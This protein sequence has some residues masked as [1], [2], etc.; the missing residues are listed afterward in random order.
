VKNEELN[1][2]KVAFI[3]CVNDEE[4]YSEALL[5]QKQLVIPSGMEAEYIPV[6]GAHSMCEGYN[7]GMAKSDAKYKVYLHQ[8]VLVV[9][10]QLIEDCLK[11]FQDHSIGLIGVIGAKALPATGIWWDSLRVV[12]RVL[13]A[14]EPESVMESV[15]QD[16][17]NGAIEDVEAV[18]G[19]IM[20]TQYD[21][22]WREDL[23]KDWHFYDISQCKEFARAG[24]RTVVPYQEE[25][26]T[27]HCPKE[28][29][30]AKA[31][32]KYQRAFLREYG[33]ELHPDF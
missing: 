33:T 26:W 18:D 16:P 24:Y 9:N 11:I 1:P 4:W 25:F 21:L 12:G 14:C 7:I 32:H 8:D 29:P 13:H 23:F 20:I 28:K 31:Y 2:N 30:L 27:I 19:L 3:S 22:P 5:Y 17:E 10:K 15:C 6:R